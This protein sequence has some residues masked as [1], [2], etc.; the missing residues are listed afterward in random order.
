MLLFWVE[1]FID[2]DPVTMIL[3]DNIFQD[4]FSNEI[5]NF[6]SGGHIFAKRVSDPERFGVV[7]FDSNKNAVQIVEKPQK[8]ISDYA[9]TGLYIYDRRVVK[10]AKKV[11]PSAR[12]E[13]EI[14]ELHNY[15]LSSGN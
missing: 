1:S 11:K 9:V 15:Y 13:I 8:W 12:G 14:T 7:K 10:A 4:D 5:K 3:G 2:D 6:K